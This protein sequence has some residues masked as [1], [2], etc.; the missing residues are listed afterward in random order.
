VTSL[1][2]AV[3]EVGADTSGF[4]SDVKK[5]VTGATNSA[6]K[7]MQNVGGKFQSAGVKM[8]AGITAPLVGVA[9]ASVKTAGQFEASM[10]VL[11]AATGTPDKAMQQLEKQAISLG[12]STVFSANEAAD[13]MLE[14]GKAGFS[15]AEITAAVPE[16][17]N[18]AATEGLAL[19]D[20]AG[21]V[22][23]ALSQFSLDAD[24][25][26]Q[27]VNALAGASN[28]SRA[29]VAT[30][31][32]SMKLVGS[33]ASGVGLT[34]QETAG[35]LAA[36]ADS[37][38]DGSV[39]GTS[40]AA[41]FNKLIPQTEKAR[42]AMEELGLDFVKGNGQF[43]DITNIAQQLQNELGNISP[44]ARKAAL[45][46]IFG[47][48][49]STLAAV[50]AVMKAGASG[51]RDYTKAA[52]DQNSAQKLAEAR[53]A[54]V[55]GAVEKMKG[56]LE[57]A[58]LVLGQAL[59]PFITKAADVIGS[60]ADRFS[61]LS[62]EA[63][64][65]IIVAAAIAAAIGPVLV[66][67]GTLISSVGTIAGVFAG[68][69]AAVA[70]PI[71]VFALLVI[72]IGLLLA[73]SEAARA[74][75][76]G[77][78][79]EIKTAV[80]SAVGPI[81]EMIQGQ[82]I[83]AFMAMWPIIEKVGVI[84]LK[85][86][87]GAVVGAVKGAIQAISGIVQVI[88]GIVQV[89]SGILTGD[90][91]KA[92]DGVKNIV[93]G[94]LDAVVGIIKVWLNVGVL[95]LF[96][97]GFTALTGLVRGGW[98]TLKGLFTKGVSTLGNALS[99]IGQAILTP[100]RVAFNAARAVV[101]AA[102][103]VIKTIFAV[104]LAVI[105]GIVTGNFGALRGIISGALATIKGIFTSGWNALKGIVTNAFNAIKGAVTT[106]VNNAVNV[107]KG[108][109]S[110]AAAVISGAVG[111]MKSAGSALIGG[112][113]AGIS[114]RID[115]AVNAV[116]SGLSKI[117]GLLPG[118]PIEWGPLKSWNNGGAG[119]RLMGF[120]TDGITA[121]IPGVVSAVA[122]AATLI[123]NGFEQVDV[124]KAVQGVTDTFTQA[125][126]AITTATQDQ[127]DR[128]VKIAEASYAKQR[129]QAEKALDAEKKR[130]EKKYAGKDE[131]KKLKRKLD[132]LEEENDKHL[133]KLDKAEKASVRALE[134]T[135]KDGNAALQAMAQRDRAAIM[136]MAATWD[137]LAATLD[138]VTEQYEAAVDDLIKK[139]DEMNNYAKGVA[140]SLIESVFGAPSDARIPAS[141]DTMVQSLQDQE[142]AAASFGGV[143]QQLADLG[144]N[145][146]SYMQ[147]VDEG[148]EGL[149]AAQALIDSGQAG[150]DTINGLQAS[151][152]AQAAN[153]GAIAADYLYGAGV[154]VAQGIVDELAARQTDLQSQMATL[155]TTLA[156]AIASALAGIT[157][158]VV[159]SVPGGGG[160]D[161]GGGDGGGNGKHQWEPKSKTNRACAKCGKPRSANVHTNRNENNAAGNL[162]SM[163]GWA[164]MGER[165]RELV[166]LPG[167]SRVYPSQ[168]TERIVGGADKPEQHFH[169][170]LP[171]GDPEAAAMAM[172]NKA[173]ARVK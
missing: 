71:A 28:A 172:M 112:L 7:S 26:G 148:T 14:L 100:F 115:D 18:L 116:K 164:M 47:N 53:M 150:I 3:V 99:K 136:N 168:Q 60:L 119:K 120:L 139:T 103:G 166:R 133:K 4:E 149:A 161:G 147:I 72:G 97:R 141:F 142:A 50:N 81:V 104:Q 22:S 54:G 109:P 78:F 75:V 85:V 77:A 158:N 95:S 20:S 62:P 73:K 58:G 69:T 169:A 111:T 118:S 29:S 127:Y 49:A 121:G 151:I 70:A 124:G 152:N 88:T 55:Q 110:K 38:L 145:P 61:N 13:A 117:K 82:L 90:W 27:V 156:A 125:S 107:V 128:Q 51:I 123:A 162:S 106:G 170:H 74:V 65:V 11:Q 93:G 159:G 76:T 157:L 138:T 129:Q 44:A 9:L 130:L 68:L 66:V 43:E 5:G 33:A 79:N 36:L 140:D 165:G 37:G 8:T 56:S 32:E 16:V 17:M 59:I 30:L 98:N 92:W 173:A 40:L 57:T 39:A 143:L 34:V 101:S 146:T 52:S 113:V 15:T 134:Q 155:G 89:V 86:F 84:I 122:N 96:R 167:G 137:G 63:Q 114:E 94:A 91:A 42:G 10:N 105:K 1:G 25:A 45:S 24:E 108:L 144:L 19:A 23:S 35:T 153:A 2:E 83:P 163:G 67:V 41:M 64:K 21:I 102:W 46:K 6:A 171:T 48:D 87:A 31:S 135:R 160:G 126:E 154:N 131:Q 132:A 80:L 12:S